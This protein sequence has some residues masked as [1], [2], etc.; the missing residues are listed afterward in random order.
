M[1]GKIENILS[2]IVGNNFRPCR[3]QKDKM[4][5]INAKGEEVPDVATCSTEMLL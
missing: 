4:C 5:I 1:A 3:N 2:I